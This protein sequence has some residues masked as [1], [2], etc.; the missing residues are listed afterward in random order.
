MNDA[1][2]VCFFEGDRDLPGQA[3]RVADLQR[4]TRDSLRQRLALQ[5]LHDEKFNAVLA[6]DIVE[7]ADMRMVES[8]NALRLTLEAFS[9]HR[10][11]SQRR[12]QDLDGNDTLESRIARFVDLAH[13]TSTERRQDFIR[14]ESGSGGERHV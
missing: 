13:P 1:F 5:I 3:Q 2:T 9:K 11:D 12:R 8:G 10:I 14:S 6:A 4:P 7:R